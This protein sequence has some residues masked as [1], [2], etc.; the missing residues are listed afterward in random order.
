[1][2]EMTFSVAFENRNWIFKD[3]SSRID[4]WVKVDKKIGAMCM[5]HMAPR[6]L[7][8]SDVGFVPGK[9]H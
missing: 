8:L 7:H 9:I 1:M 5:M 3:L 4:S 2:S 6:F